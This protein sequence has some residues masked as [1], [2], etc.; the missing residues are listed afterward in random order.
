MRETDDK[1]KYRKNLSKRDITIPR[2]D[3]V[4]SSKYVL[5]VISLGFVKLAALWLCKVIAKL[6]FLLIVWAA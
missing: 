2:A 3:Y 1:R 4:N 6:H 5:Y